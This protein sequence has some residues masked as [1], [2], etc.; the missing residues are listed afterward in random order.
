MDAARHPPTQSYIQESPGLDDQ[1][2]AHR[3]GDKIERLTGRRVDLQIDHDDASKLDV[4]LS[5]EVP[6]VI[7]GANIF[8]YSGFARLCI[9]YA[10]ASIQRQR[11]IDLLEFHLLLA[12][13]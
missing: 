5:R 8:H 13:N 3:I 9:E 2:F 7:L 6:L 4:D 11:P 10:A 1:Q 12:R